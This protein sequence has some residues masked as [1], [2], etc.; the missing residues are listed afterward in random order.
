[1]RLVGIHNS[2]KISQEKS[3]STSFK[4]ISAQSMTQVNLQSK[5]KALLSQLNSVIVG[6][7]E[8]VPDCVACLLA[9]GHC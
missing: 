6:K 5:L 2:A 7:P 3:Q 1:M 8:Q 4:A 9:G